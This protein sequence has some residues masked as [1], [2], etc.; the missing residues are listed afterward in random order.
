MGPG[1]ILIIHPQDSDCSAL[2]SVLSRE[3]Y[4]VVEAS[5]DMGKVPFD[6]GDCCVMLLDM[7]AG[8]PAAISSRQ[9][10]HRVGALALNPPNSRPRR[11][12]RRKHRRISRKQRPSLKAIK[13]G[14]KT[15]T[16]GTRLV[17]GG[18]GEVRLTRFEWSILSQLYAHVN[19]TVP[20]VE[21]V[22]KLW[23]SDPTKGVHSLRAFIKNL[24]KKIEPEPTHPQY[25]VTDL[26][27]GYRLR[28]SP[29][30]SER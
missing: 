4:E 18:S 26:A 27:L 10:Q 15:V 24:R 16:L 25:I 6:I 7:L 22:R 5:L 20:S 12:V 19:Q 3:R 23:P 2:K 28:L 9:P 13:L 30:V 8:A 14:D 11:V 29:S 17:R 21:L 1:K